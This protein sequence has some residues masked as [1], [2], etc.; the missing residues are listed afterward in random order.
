M[1]FLASWASGFTW[2]SVFTDVIGDKNRNCS[3][4]V[5]VRINMLITHVIGLQQRAWSCVGDLEKSPRAQ[6]RQEDWRQQCSL[7]DFVSDLIQWF[8]VFSREI[9]P[10]KR[11]FLGI[12]KREQREALMKAW[13]VFFSPVFLIEILCF[14]GGS[15]KESACQCKRCRFDHRVRKIPLE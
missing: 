2:A 15:I 9:L 4:G 5:L 12:G 3:P 1:H 7:F 14:S 10:D 11:P 8:P 13:K 6:S